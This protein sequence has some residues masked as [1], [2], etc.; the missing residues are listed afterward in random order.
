[1]T[2]EN[3]VTKAESQI[4]DTADFDRFL[5]SFTV[6]RFPNPLVIIRHV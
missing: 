4:F 2:T 6:V 5:P 3:N 1:M